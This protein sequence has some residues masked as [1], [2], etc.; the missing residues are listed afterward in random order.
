MAFA[1]AFLATF[2]LGG[3]TGIHNGSAA[4][5]IYIHDSYFVVAHFH[6]SVPVGPI[7]A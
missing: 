3:V 1:L 4:A 2:L 7:A 6:S 5:D